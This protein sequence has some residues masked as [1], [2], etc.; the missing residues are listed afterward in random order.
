MLFFKTL[1]IALIFSSIGFKKFIYFIS[2]GYGFSIAI[3]GLFLLY[4]SK[5]NL[6]LVEIILGLLYIIYGLRLALFLALRELK[7]EYYN[8]KILKDL[9]KGNEMKTIIKFFIWISVSLLY[10]CQSSPLTFRTLSNVKDDKLLSYIGIIIMFCGFLLE[11]WA[12]HQKS[13]AKKINPKRFVDTGLYTIVRCPNYFGE[14]IFWTGNFIGGLKIYN[15]FFQWFIAILGYITIIYIMFSGARRIEERQ[16]KSYGE[17]P[18][19]KKY[20]KTT[21]ILIPFLPLYSVEK[22]TWLRG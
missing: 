10:A 6:T 21:P 12:D 15:G 1:V 20:V 2:I 16:N 11:V 8:K 14:M 3:I 19:Y 5:T 17:D 18:A 9:E 4:N 22:Y 13:E 7:N